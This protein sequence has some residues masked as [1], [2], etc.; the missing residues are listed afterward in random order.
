MVIVSRDRA[1]NNE[2]GKHGA[3]GYAQ[4]LNIT[5]AEGGD[6]E[7]Q[8]ERIADCCANDRRGE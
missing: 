7:S 6:A 5:H 2:D 8:P 4:H 3:K 1:A